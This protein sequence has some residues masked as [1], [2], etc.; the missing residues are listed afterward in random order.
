MIISASRRTDIPSYYSDWFFNRIK[1]GFVL[2]RNPMNYH[3]ISRI[4]INP[5]IVDGIVFW[6]KNPEPM[7]KRLAELNEY[8]FYFQFTL[9]SYGKDI[10]PHLPHKTKDILPIFKKVSNMIGPDRIIWRYDPILINTK[11][12]ID[13]HT[14]AFSKI[15][16]ELSEYT[17]T[18]TISFID[19]NYKGLKSNINKLNLTDFTDETQTKLA[20]CLAP[21]AHEYGLF[22]NTCAEKADLQPYGIE[23]AQCIDA[24]LFSKLLSSKIDIKKD[25]N[26][27]LECGCASSIDIGMYNS[28]MN[29]CL[30][31][32][33]NYNPQTILSNHAKHNPLSP[34]L[35]GEAEI[36]DKITDRITG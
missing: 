18:V 10:E 20:S 1:A 9:T 26:Q 34:L 29:G 14:T 19:T 30:Y 6:T 3:Q 16:K 27:R 22:I 12:T 15:A 17:K 2:V 31:C 5:E 36:G 25:R 11:Y 33:A 21:I 4:K 35:F 24:Q 13:Y 7:I 28:C 23:R 32:Y 8:M